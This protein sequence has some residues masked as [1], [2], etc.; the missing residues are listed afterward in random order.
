ME[1]IPL[2]LAKKGWRW[3]KNCGI[4]IVGTGGFRA[5]PKR[6]TELD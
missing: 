6:A 5:L 1:Q 3:W 2:D 4:K